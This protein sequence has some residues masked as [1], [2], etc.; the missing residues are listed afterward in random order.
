MNKPLIIIGNG[1]HAAV[2]V[3][4]LIAQQRIIIGYTAPN[5]KKAFSIYHIWVRMMLLLII[6]PMR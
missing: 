3:E 6:T 2:L 4:I 1:G 5:E